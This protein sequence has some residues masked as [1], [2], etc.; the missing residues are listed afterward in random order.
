MGKLSNSLFFH[1]THVLVL[2]VTTCCGYLYAINS[3][4]STT[5]SVS[6]STD[7]KS[8]LALTFYLT[9]EP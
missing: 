2:I 3:V 1:E 8:D 9:D 4:L 6:L 5:L 7:P